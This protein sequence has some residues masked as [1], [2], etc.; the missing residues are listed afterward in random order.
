MSLPKILRASRKISWP[1]PTVYKFSCL[2]VGPKSEFSYY[3][4]KKYINRTILGSWAISYCIET[5]GENTPDI[6][7]I[8]FL[9]LQDSLQF[10]LMYG[11]RAEKVYIWPSTLSFYITEYI[12]EETNNNFEADKN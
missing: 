8:S 9:D 4:V 1:N 6:C 2:G 5:W 3:S 11:D 7:Y 10:K 12:D